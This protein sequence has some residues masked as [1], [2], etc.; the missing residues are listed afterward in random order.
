MTSSN[1]PE[2]HTLLAIETDERFGTFAEGR[3]L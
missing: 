1:V 3:W 2:I